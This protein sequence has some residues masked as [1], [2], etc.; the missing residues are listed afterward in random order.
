MCGPFDEAVHVIAEMT[1]ARIP[2]RSAEQVVIDAAA[3][4]DSFYEQRASTTGALARRDI[5]VGAIDCKGIPMVKPEP[6]RRVA[7][8]KKGEKPQKK[9]MATVAAVFACAPRRRTPEAVL[10]SLFCDETVPKRRTQRQ[11]P[12]DKRV[13]ASLVA[14][15]DNFIADV[16]AEMTRR[17]PERSSAKQIIERYARRMTIEQRLAEAIR[18][19]HLDA[20]SSAVPLNVDLD[21][22][23]SVL[24]GAACASL[25]RRLGTG[26]TNATP[27]TL[28]RRFLHT[29]GLIINR[30]D[31]ITVRLDRRTYSPVLRSA[32]IP[33]T[34]VPWWGDRTLQ[35][36]YA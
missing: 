23:L 36:E 12:K 2:K 6:A 31:T 30:G 15:K 29:G 7:R 19:F 26:Y 11:R 8:R 32:D 18:A 27:D 4:V 13:W 20:L 24:A 21:I 33:D 16:K 35:F 14:G 17:D 5:V 28:Q 10:R 3:D 25:R 1:G 22:V 9:K 34:T